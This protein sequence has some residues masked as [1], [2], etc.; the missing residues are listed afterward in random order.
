MTKRVPFNLLLYNRTRYFTD[1][2]EQLSISKH[3]SFLSHTRKNAI[4]GEK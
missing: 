4:K 3:L 2:F 1:M